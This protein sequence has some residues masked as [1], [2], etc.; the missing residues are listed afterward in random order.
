MNTDRG[1]N[2][3]GPANAQLLLGKETKIILGCAFEVLNQ[4]GHG[5]PE[6]TYEN[7]LSV[8]FRHKEIPFDQQRRFPVISSS[9]KR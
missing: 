8:S 7:G 9:A 4:I 5:L 3:T 6:K 2:L 1:V